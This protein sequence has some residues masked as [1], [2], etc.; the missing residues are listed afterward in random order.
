LHRRRFLHGS[1]LRAIGAKDIAWLRG[2]PSGPSGEMLA[3]DWQNAQRHAL[4][5]VLHGN[6]IE[7]R[8]PQ[9]E[10]IVGD[11]LAMLLNAGREPVI[12][13]LT[14]HADHPPASWETLVDTA[15]PPDNGAAIYGANKPVRVPERT[16]L[17]LRE[18]LPQG[19]S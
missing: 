16:L 5:L 2:D 19:S 10:P 18:I 13:D 15:R 17:L 14:R 9:G 3:A 12:F 1:L 7:E 4:G 6:A 11:T 8:G